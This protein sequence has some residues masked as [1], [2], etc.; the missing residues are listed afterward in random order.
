MMH[1]QITS[2]RS[3]PYDLTAAEFQAELHR[4]W[5]DGYVPVNASAFVEGKIAIPKGRRPVVMTFDDG[6][7]SQ[8][9]L[10]A[11]GTVNPNT[12]VGIM[13]AFYAK[14]PD[15][16]PA[17]TFY[18]NDNPFGLSGS[19]LSRALKWLT[20]NGFEIGNH[21]LTHANLSQLDSTG[22][23]KELAEEAKVID[24][25][26]PGYHISSMALPFGVTPSPNSLA[27]SG[28]WGGT[29]YGPYSVMLVGANPSPSPFSTQFD[30][31]AIPRIRSAH[32]P[33]KTTQDYEFDYWQSQLEKDPGSVYV[34]DGDPNTISFPKSEE[35]ELASKFRSRAKPY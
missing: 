16:K 15:F 6:S 2:D 18:V 22:V 21:T 32:F 31:A 3:S 30:P 24:G 33:W 35:S 1:H 10:E 26:L 28:S 13:E 25:A 7:S 4:L 9:G 34:S 29:S 23:Q 12:A 14:H 20:T 8:F 11:D 27:V 17:G 5:K 19:S